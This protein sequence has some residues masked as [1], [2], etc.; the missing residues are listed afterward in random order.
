[1]SAKKTYIRMETPRAARLYA[2]NITTARRDGAQHDIEWYYTESDSAEIMCRTDEREE[3]ENEAS[4]ILD[5]DTLSPDAFAALAQWLAESCNL[6]VSD[7][8][9]ECPKSETE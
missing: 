7:V 6:R 1:M 8:T 2:R 9:A 4:T 3:F 5:S